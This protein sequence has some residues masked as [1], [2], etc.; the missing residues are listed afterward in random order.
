MVLV[1]RPV[2]G[3]TVF[4]IGSIT[5]VFT[6]TLLGDMANRGEVRPDDPVTKYLPPTVRMPSRNGKV[7]TLAH[8]ASHHSGLPRELE[9]R[10]P[11]E[12]KPSPAYRLRTAPGPWDRLRIL[13]SR[14]G[15][16]WGFTLPA[17]RH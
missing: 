16:A 4:E 15:P 6:G 10:P 12:N 13:E 14:H 11:G 5:K 17:S 1:S 2:D 3:N 7:I 8:L 9:N